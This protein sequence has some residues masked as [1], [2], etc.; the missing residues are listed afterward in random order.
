MWKDLVL[1]V[2]VHILS[3]THG[4]C[5]IPKVAVL[6]KCDFLIHTVMSNEP[7]VT[8]CMYA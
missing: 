2:S 4:G 6:D 7:G 8:H 3:T 5:I 1:D